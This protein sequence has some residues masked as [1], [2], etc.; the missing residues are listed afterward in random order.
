[1][2]KQKGYAVEELPDEEDEP[3]YANCRGTLKVLHIQCK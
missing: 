1:M 3:P 2:F